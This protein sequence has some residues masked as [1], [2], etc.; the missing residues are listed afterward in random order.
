MSLDVLGHGTLGVII[1]H[2]AIFRRVICW[3]AYYLLQL[4]LRAKWRLIIIIIGSDTRFSTRI[5]LHVFLRI[6]T[7]YYVE[8]ILGD[9]TVAS[10]VLR[11]DKW[12]LQQLLHICIRIYSS[13]LKLFARLGA[14]IGLELG[15]GLLIIIFLDVSAWRL[16]NWKHGEVA[17]V[18]WASYHWFRDFRAIGIADYHAWLEG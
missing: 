12:K 14:Q 13:T 16:G 5:D 10:L 9:L 3:D 17:V 1:P 2:D 11:V 7:I 15:L 4:W 18:N 6:T 8:A